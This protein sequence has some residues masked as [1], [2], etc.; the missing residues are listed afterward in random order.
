MIV[1]IFGYYDERNF[2][3]D[4]MAILFAQHISSLGYHCLV[5]GHPDLK[6][7]GYGFDTT[8]DLIYFHSNIDILILGGGGYLV[9]NPTPNIFFDR[10]GQLVEACKRKSIPMCGFSLGGIGGE[11]DQLN[12][13]VQELIK[14]ASFL[15]IRTHV[16]ADQLLRYNAN[17]HFNHDVVWLTPKVDPFSLIIPEKGGRRLRIGVCFRRRRYRWPLMA[18]ALHILVY[19]RNDV[20]FIF[21]DLAADKT[22]F[23]GLRV[24]GNRP[25]LESYWCEDPVSTAKKIVSLDMLVSSTLHLGMVATA[26]GIKNCDL[27]ADKKARLGF[28]MAG[29]VKYRSNL[30]NDV[31]LYAQLL[32]RK[33]TQAL[34]KKQ[35]EPCVQAA[36]KSAENSLNQLAAVL[37]EAALHAGITSRSSTA[38]KRNHK[39]D[40]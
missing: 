16:D 13:N 29:L 1:G 30:L 21:I 4:L 11:M 10:V 40:I 31:F 34:S 35:V 33:Q 20:D 7:E 22:T 14:S 8:Q 9:P 25:N 37:K 23:K 6:K 18:I 5:F 27:F 36:Q 15:S 17:T 12:C 32:S 3:D 28:R 24:N 19:L 26:F 2:G 38:L 39:S